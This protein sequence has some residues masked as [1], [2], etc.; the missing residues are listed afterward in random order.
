MGLD[1]YLNAKLHFHDNGMQSEKHLEE[2]ND[3][4][5]TIGVADLNVCRRATVNLEVLYWRKANQIHAW[6]VKN[7]QSGKDDCNKYYVSMKQ[8]NELFELCMK[9]LD[10]KETSKALETVMELL[11]PQSGFFYGGTTVDDYYWGQVEYTAA[12][13]DFILNHSVLKGA[14]FCYQSS[15]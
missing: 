7:V 10:S 11:P 15:W 1:M 2:F 12:S 9:V 13:L 5:K 3:L 6:F 8:L 4:M 14:D